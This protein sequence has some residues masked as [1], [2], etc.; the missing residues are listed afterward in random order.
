MLN[1]STVLFPQ[2]SVL[3]AWEPIALLRHVLVTLDFNRSEIMSLLTVRLFPASKHPVAYV[4]LLLLVAVSS[5]KD[6]K[7]VLN[8][9]FSHLVIVLQDFTAFLLLQM[10][11]RV[12]IIDIKKIKLFQKISIRKRQVRLF[13]IYI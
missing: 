11:V 10:N 12:I 4:P 1:V 3:I 7:I 13:E 2:A 6:H 8:L 9:A 5:V